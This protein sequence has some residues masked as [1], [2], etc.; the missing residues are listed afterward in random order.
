MIDAVI[1][2]GSAVSRS[3]YRGCTQIWMFTVA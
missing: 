2:C 1:Y 3:T